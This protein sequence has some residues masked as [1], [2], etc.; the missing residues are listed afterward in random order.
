MNQ[1]EFRIRTKTDGIL[2]LAQAVLIYRGASDSALLR[3]SFW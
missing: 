1:A 2:R 3:S